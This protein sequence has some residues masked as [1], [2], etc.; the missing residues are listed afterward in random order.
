MDQA[1]VAVATLIVVF[2]LYVFGPFALLWC[3]QTLGLTTLTM[4][5]KVWLACAGLML[6]LRGGS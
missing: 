4:S 3:L 2:C 6:F 1:A 5:F